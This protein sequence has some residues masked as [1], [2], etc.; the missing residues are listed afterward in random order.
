MVCGSWSLLHFFAF[1]DHND[2]LFCRCRAGKKVRKCQSVTRKCVGAEPQRCY[3]VGTESRTHFT[4][5]PRYVTSAYT[6]CRLQD[7]AAVKADSSPQAVS[8][9]D[10]SSALPNVQPNLWDARLDPTSVSLS[11]LNCNRKRTCIAVLTV[12]DVWVLNAPLFV[13]L[14]VEKS[15][16]WSLIAESLTFTR[17]S[18]DLQK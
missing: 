17:P 2:V 16:K 1:F 13:L 12:V 15:N 9:W 6:G 11:R 4:T 8:V 3:S 18:Q 10:Q 5:A 14:C 7:V